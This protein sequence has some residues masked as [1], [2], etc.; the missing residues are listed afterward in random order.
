MRASLRAE[1]LPIDTWSSLPA[2]L[3]IESTLAGNASDL[4]SETSAAALYC[5]IM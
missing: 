5:A 3:G 4:H 1:M 2:E